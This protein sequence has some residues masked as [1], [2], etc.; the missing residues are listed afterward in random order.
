[1]RGATKEADDLELEKLAGKIN[2]LLDILYAQG[3]R[4]ILLILQGMDASGKDGKV[5]H[6]FSECDPLGIR[7]TNLFAYL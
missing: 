4:K 6:V 7:L 3:K 1:V 2:A 5:R